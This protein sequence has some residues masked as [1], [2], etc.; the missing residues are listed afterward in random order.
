MQPRPPTA[1]N[2]LTR[3]TYLERTTTLSRADRSMH[4]TPPKQGSDTSRRGCI[5]LRRLLVRHV[6]THFMHV[7]R[8]LVCRCRRRGGC[9]RSRRGRGRCGSLGERDGSKQG[10]NQGCSKLLHWMS[11]VGSKA[12]IHYVVHCHNASGSVSLTSGNRLRELVPIALHRQPSLHLLASARQPDTTR[13]ATIMAADRHAHRCC[14]ST[15]VPPWEV[16][17]HPF[18]EAH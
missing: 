11:P 3:S 18:G 8:R 10:C 5:L 2:T 4:K 16:V 13:S 9:G 7:L 14:T 6:V 1:A 15:Q 12:T 17:F